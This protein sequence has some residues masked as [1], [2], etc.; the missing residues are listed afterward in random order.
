[1]PSPVCF[2][3]WPSCVASASR[4]IASC[5]WSSAIARSSPSRS[6]ISVEPQMSVNSTARTAEAVY[7]V[8]TGMLGQRTEE[9]LDGPGL[10]LDDVAAHLAVRLTV[11]LL[12][13]LDARPLG[14]AEHRPG[15]GFEPV[16]QEPNPVR[17]LHADIRGV[18]GRDLLGS[19][20]GTSCRSM[21]K[22]TNV[23]VRHALRGRQ[24][25]RA[26]PSRIAR[27]GSAT[28]STWS[29]ARCCPHR[30]FSVIDVRRRPGSMSRR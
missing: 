8:P 11:H 19:A 1:M 5:S 28:R 3:S 12:D 10:D 16:R 20:P 21:Y 6:V 27:A 14:E 13:R 4:T 17:R 7:A 23:I 24:R 26:R 18:R 22:G 2:T 29:R 30:L 25:R 9:R 15:L